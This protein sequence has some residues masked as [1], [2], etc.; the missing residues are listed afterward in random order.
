MTAQQVEGTPTVVSPVDGELG[1]SSRLS[2]S[3]A[4]RAGLPT[5]GD[6]GLRGHPARPAKRAAIVRAS[7]YQV[8]SETG[9]LIAAASVSAG[10]F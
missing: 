8:A 9:A 3:P 6:A 7:C 2:A 4:G 10:S 1:G 5:R